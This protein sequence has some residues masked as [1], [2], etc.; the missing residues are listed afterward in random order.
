MC[1]RHVEISDRAIV[2]VHLWQSK[3]RLSGLHECFWLLINSVGDHKMG[4]ISRYRHTCRIVIYFLIEIGAHTLR[5]RS[6]LDTVFCCADL[7][8]AVPER[9]QHVR[10]GV[11]AGSGEVLGDAGVQPPGGPAAHLAAAAALFSNSGGLLEAVETLLEL[12]V[13]HTTA[14]PQPLSPIFPVLSWEEPAMQSSLLI[15][16]YYGES[17]KAHHPEIF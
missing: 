13:H 6:L 8:E 4:T 2:Q 1:S 16:K 5:E 17:G 3:G 15:A 12:Q 10:L 7:P 11:V 9:L 14:A